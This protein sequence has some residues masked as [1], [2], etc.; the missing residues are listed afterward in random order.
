MNNTKTIE[1]S[2]FET[3]REIAEKMYTEESNELFRKKEHLETKAQL[4]ETKIQLLEKELENCKIEL[5]E[6]DNAR[7]LFEYI[8]PVSDFIEERILYKK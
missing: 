5:K 4:L 6:V 8:N 3:G 7:I 1:N 2:A